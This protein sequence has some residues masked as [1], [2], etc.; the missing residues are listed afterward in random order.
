[1]TRELYDGLASEL[2]EM[3]AK[4]S[5]CPEYL[6]EAVLNGMIMAFIAPPYLAEQPADVG[7]LPMQT[8]E[9]TSVAPN[10][11]SSDWD[12]RRE[13]LRLAKQHRVD[14]KK[15][16]GEEF[17]T[18]V[19]YIFKRNPEEH[20]EDGITA[21][22]LTEASRTADRRLPGNA[23]ATFSRAKEK[24]WLDKAEG[25]GVYCLAPKGENFVYDLRN[26]NDGA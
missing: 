2:P 15:L 19:A 25:K 1:M 10:V 18:F 14:L 13:M 21:E 24:G 20:Q 16:N 8:T 6:Q 7:E 3:L 17:A 4:V 5:T 11:D 12:Y 23:S 26:S 22:I 9:V